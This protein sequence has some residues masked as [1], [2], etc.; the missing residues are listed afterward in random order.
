MMNPD[1][2]QLI[3]LL[4]LAGYILYCT[5]YY[6]APMFILKVMLFFAHMKYRDIDISFRDEKITVKLMKDGEERVIERAPDIDPTMRYFAATICS[7]FISILRELRK[8]PVT[9]RPAEDTE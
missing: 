4:A 2:L 8:G 6:A 3:P 1:Y 9:D 7:E 5:Y